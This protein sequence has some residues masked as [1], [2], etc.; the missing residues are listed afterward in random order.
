VVGEFAEAPAF[1]G[2][3]VELVVAE[4][5]QPV[6]PDAGEAGQPAAG[7]V[8]VLRGEGGEVGLGGDGGGVPVVGLGLLAGQPGLQLGQMVD[9]VVGDPADRLVR[10]RGRRRG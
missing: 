8:Q 2:R 7:L 5:V 4:G 3:V 9:E 10:G 6:R 1:A